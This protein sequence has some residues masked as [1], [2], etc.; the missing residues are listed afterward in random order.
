MDSAPT[1]GTSRVWTLVA[2]A[3]VAAVSL[4][5]WRD[6]PVAWD[7]WMETLAPRTVQLLSLG[8]ALLAALAAAAW[9]EAF[10]GPGTGWLG[11]VVLALI[12]AWRGQAL[13]SPRELLSSVLFTA[14]VFRLARVS[15]RWAVPLAG[16]GVTALAWGMPL[17]DPRAEYLLAGRFYT[18]TTLPGNWLP[19]WL[20]FTTPGVV[21]FAAMVGVWAGVRYSPRAMAIIA[22]QTIA[23]TIAIIAMHRVSGEGTRTL[24]IVFPLVS[25]M[26]AS[27]LWQVMGWLKT[28]WA[29]TGMRAVLLVAAG[30]LVAAQVMLHPYGY[31]WFNGLAG[32]LAGAYQR[33]ETDSLGLSLRD[34]TDWVSARAPQGARVVVAGNEKLARQGLRGDL[35]VHALGE[36]GKPP[37]RPYLLVAVPHANWQEQAAGCAEVYRVERDHVPL[38][39]VQSC[40][41]REAHIHLP[42][43]GCEH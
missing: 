2:L 40:A 4:A 35:E 43:D 6:A 29:R 34:A 32:G 42:G 12:P 26:A 13:H 33:H 37:P 14:G 39:T 41:L 18:P 20:L 10:R 16:L 31:L 38:T 25:A 22:F 27:G 23:W 28:R 1:T 7:P 5:E 30:Q 3:C 15:A 21:A 8:M 9:V 17:P 36:G 11:V 19:T 24:M